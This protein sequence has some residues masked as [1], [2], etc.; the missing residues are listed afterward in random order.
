MG[1]HMARRIA[2]AGHD[3]VA[4]NRTA[5]KAEALSAQGYRTCLFAAWAR[6]ATK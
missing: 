4:W 2:Q 1:G 3:M 6:M 5:A